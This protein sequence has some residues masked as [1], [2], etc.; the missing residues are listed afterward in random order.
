MLYGAQYAPALSLARL[1]LAQFS[2]VFQVLDGDGGGSIGADEFVSFVSK[3]VSSGGS[4]EG[5]PERNMEDAH[6]KMTKLIES[7]DK[8]GGGEVPA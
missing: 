5:S 6:M 1:K 2:E 4:K 7:V 3:V 8:D